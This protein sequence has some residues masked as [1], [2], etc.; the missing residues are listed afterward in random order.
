MNNSWIM[1]HRTAE[2][3]SAQRRR[4]VSALLLSAAVHVLILL[5]LPGFAVSQHA[6]PELLIELM[7]LKPL[8][9][10][11]AGF[12]G[13]TGDVASS[14][15]PGPNLP[16]GPSKPQ[17]N[18]TTTKPAA[19]PAGPA[20]AKPAPPQPKPAETSQQ[21]PTPSQQAA[22]NTATSVVVADQPT[23]QAEKPATKPQPPANPPAPAKESPPAKPAEQPAGNPSAGTDTAPA[24]SQPSDKP[25]DPSGPTAQPPSGGAGGQG[26]PST[27]PPAAPPGPSQ[28]EL[29]LLGDYGAAA[30]KRIRSQCR[31]SEQGA[32]GTV[33][34]EFEVDRKGRLLD[35]RV[36]ESSGHNNLDNDALEATRAAFN[37]KH[38]I[39]PFP[40]DITVPDWKFR[41]SIKYPLY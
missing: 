23:K 20:A 6:A 18:Q 26:A 13:D 14:P 27:G 9:V 12:A 30:A 28:Q 17:P 15:E 10:Q 7:Q 16:S 21:K 24:G 1:Q 36:V 8:P 22:G 35:V 40:K 33:K 31:N 2:R 38:E 11:A 5:M 41:T 19:K 34:I 39:I 25:T 4:D 37:E 3:L 29:N 32:R